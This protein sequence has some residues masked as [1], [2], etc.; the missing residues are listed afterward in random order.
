[1]NISELQK[2]AQTVHQ[3]Y[4]ELNAR[5]GHTKWGGTYYVAGFARG[6]GDH[7]VILDGC[8]VGIA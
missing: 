8:H 1:M 5:D 4:D 6:M 7:V 3:K 2:R